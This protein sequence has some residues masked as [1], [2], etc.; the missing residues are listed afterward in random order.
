MKNNFSVFGSVKF[1]MLS[2]CHFLPTMV[3]VLNHL[4]VLD[5][6]SLSGP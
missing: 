3:T 4:S 2:V 5:S 1:I 6:T